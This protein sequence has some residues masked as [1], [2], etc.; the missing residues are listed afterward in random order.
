MHL[1]YEYSASG[2]FRGKPLEI[3]SNQRQI[4]VPEVKVQA[5]QD[6]DLGSGN[7]PVSSH[8]TEAINL[9]PSPASAAHGSKVPAK[10]AKE[11]SMDGF[12]PAVL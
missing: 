10:G 11:G 1:F 9:R 3:S 4:R 5:P 8:G 7:I 12:N 6:I 2:K